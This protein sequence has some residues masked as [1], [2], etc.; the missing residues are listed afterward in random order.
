MI[1]SGPATNQSTRAL[2]VLTFFFCCFSLQLV[3]PSGCGFPPRSALLLFPFFSVTSALVSRDAA[4]D[5]TQSWNR[6]KGRRSSPGPLLSFCRRLLS[7]CR[8][9]RTHLW[10]RLAFDEKVVNLPSSSAPP[11]FFSPPQAHCPRA[12]IPLRCLA[13]SPMSPLP[14]LNQDNRQLQFNFSP[15]LLSLFV[16]LVNCLVSIAPRHHLFCFTT[17]F[18][19]RNNSQ[20]QRH[21]YLDQSSS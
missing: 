3:F 16:S 11:I 1:L 10:R 4:P 19:F 13:V 6:F 7:S 21:L 17:P 12:T 15:P 5:S 9:L 20:V 18:F 14:R 2:P 8:P